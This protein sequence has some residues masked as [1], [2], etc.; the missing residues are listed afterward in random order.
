VQ[1]LPV[2]DFFGKD[3]SRCQL[4]HGENLSVKMMYLCLKKL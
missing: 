3:V 4:D 1:P 2:E